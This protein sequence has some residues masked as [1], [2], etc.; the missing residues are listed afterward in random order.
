MTLTEHLEALRSMFMRILLILT[1]AFVICINFSDRIAAFLLAHLQVAVQ[2]HG[3]IVY[4]GIFDKVVS[5][6]QV[7]FWSAIV[8]SAPLWLLQIWKFIGPGLRDSEKK[9]IKPFVI[10]SLI[11]FYAGVCF[12]YFLVF[13]FALK[14][15]LGMGVENVEPTIGM[16]QYLLLCSNVLVLLGFMFQLPNVMVIFRVLGIIGRGSVSEIRRYAYVAFA[17]FA[18]LITPTT[19]ALTMLMLWIPLVVLFEIGAVAVFLVR[20][21]VKQG[22]QK[23]LE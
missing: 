15:L 20:P 12:G 23:C 18:A 5:Q 21:A 11:L 13:P 8:I 4:L 2:G 1:C 17:I 7:A 10:V 3:K 16:K 19:D 14:T 9:I 22:E 6:F